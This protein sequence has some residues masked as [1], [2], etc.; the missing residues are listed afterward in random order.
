MRFDDPHWLA[1]GALAC[2]VLIGTWYWHD[3]RQ[4]SALEQLIA[5]HLRHRLTGSVSWTRR[6]LQRGLLL[7][8]VLCL[9]CALAGPL[10]GF[11]LQDTTRR[12]N[13]VVF[14]IDTSRSM[15]TQD[16]KPDRLTRA[17]LAIDDMARKL[18]GDVIGL[19][20]F[21]GSAFLVCPPTF[22]QDAFQQSLE[23]VGTDTIPRGGTNIPSAIRVAQAAFSRSPADDRI[24]ILVTD[25]ENL[26]GDALAAAKIAARQDGLKIYTV[27]VGTT[28]GALIPIPADHGGGFVRDERGDLVRSRL[29]AAGLEA[30]AAA[31]SAAYVHVGDQGADFDAFLRQ[32]FTSVAKHDLIYRR[33]KVYDERYQWPLA[34]ALILLLASLIVSTRRSGRRPTPAVALTAALSASCFVT[35]AL[36][37]SVRAE[38]ADRGADLSR[39]R[40]ESPVADY[41][42]GTSAY[43][44]GYF[45]QAARLFQQSIR[46]AP[47]SDATRVADQQDAY[48][49][50]GD[51]LY[52]AGQQ[53]EKSD[54]PQTMQKWVE[55]VRAYDTALQLRPDDADSRYNRDFVERQIVA[56][57]RL[58]LDNG[59]QGKGHRQNGGQGRGQTA[60]SS[61][62]QPPPPGPS[63][64]QGEPRPQ[65][66][67]PNH[68]RSGQRASGQMTLEEARELL[69]SDEPEEHLALTILPGRRAPGRTA[70]GAFRNW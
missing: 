51:A 3:R 18:D 38:S 28:E 54:L 16:V 42:A 12:A 34:A 62:R 9:C 46:S 60:S 14:A 69:D 49:D 56:L 2:L 10:L 52:R 27:G 70:N 59:G 19:V 37:I 66:S 44:A 57:E 45:L 33:R 68:Q 8:S 20:A 67:T 22:D 17:K 32:A 53:L 39:V 63:R 29:D 1:G 61:Q 35:A 23:A 7:G 25:G 47:A 55:A 30:I 65:P 24:L 4:R 64:Q 40:A 6:F 11:R 58:E 50:L 26:E 31:T 15:L 48:Y 21:S 43:R 36:I 5:P 41:N 13:E